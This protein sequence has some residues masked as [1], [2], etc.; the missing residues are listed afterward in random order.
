MEPLRTCIGC[1]Q[2][3]PQEKLIRINRDKTG[4]IS[5]DTYRRLPGRGA[6]IC[7]SEDC[8]DKALKKRKLNKAFRTEV[9]PE[10]YELIREE[11][12]NRGKIEK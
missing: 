7:G 2:V 9:E 1:G 3:M 12:K 8:V 6:Y 5:V 11:I 10:I 4:R